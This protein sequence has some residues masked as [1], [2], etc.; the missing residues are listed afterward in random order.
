MGTRT[1]NTGNR[2][3][4][5]SWAAALTVEVSKLEG[6]RTTAWLAL[7]IVVVFAGAFVL[8][9]GSPSPDFWDSVSD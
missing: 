7:S 9:S 8:V 3:T 5:R 2:S 6:L 4:L 1:A